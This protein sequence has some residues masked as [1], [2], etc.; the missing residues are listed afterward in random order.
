M[1]VTL[2]SS[3]T[4]SCSSHTERTHCEKRINT[5]ASVL[6]MLKA[7]RAWTGLPIPHAQKGK[8]MGLFLDELRLSLA[9]LKAP[10]EQVGDGQAAY[11]RGKSRAGK[12][13]KIQRGARE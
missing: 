5:L 3:R 6:A 1:N 9:L 12:G 11:L 4:H 2:V 7:P 13:S 10:L 8:C